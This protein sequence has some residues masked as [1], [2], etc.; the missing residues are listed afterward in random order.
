[1][2]GVKFLT[3]QCIIHDKIVSEGVKVGKILNIIKF[4]EKLHV[5]FTALQTR[6]EGAKGTEG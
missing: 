3:A 5:S 2:W 1:M 6:S 4:V